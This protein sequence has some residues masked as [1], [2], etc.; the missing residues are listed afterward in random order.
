MISLNRIHITELLSLSRRFYRLPRLQRRPGD[1]HFRR[2]Y[3]FDDSLA[4]TSPAGQSGMRLSQWRFR[5]F[6]QKTYVGLVFEKFV[7]D[8]ADAVVQRLFGS[9]CIL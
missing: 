7:F 4:S 3:H 6:G 8:S 5:L 9:W 2:L 1:V